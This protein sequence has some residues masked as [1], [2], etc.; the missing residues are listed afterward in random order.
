MALFIE[1]AEKKDVLKAA[2][3][4]ETKLVKADNTFGASA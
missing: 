4:L 3:R 1:K 2:K